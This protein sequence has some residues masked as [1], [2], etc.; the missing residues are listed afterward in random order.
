M[1]MLSIITVKVDNNHSFSMKT[2]YKG[3]TNFD[4]E[5]ACKGRQTENDESWSNRGFQTPLR[6][7]KMWK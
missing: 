3:C 7:S 5:N 2:K 4:D 6:D 1:L